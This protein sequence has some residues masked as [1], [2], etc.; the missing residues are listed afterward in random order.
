MTI[1]ADETVRQDAARIKAGY[2]NEL[3]RNNAEIAS[4]TASIASLEAR[5]AWL[6]GLITSYTNSIPAPKDEGV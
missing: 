4:H 6:E 2:A 5:N 1:E 3:K